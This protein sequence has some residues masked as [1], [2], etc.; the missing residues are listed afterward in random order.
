MTK[1]RNS[2]SPLEESSRYVLLDEAA[3]NRLIDAKLTAAQYRTVL[4][5]SLVDPFGNRFV[6]TSGQMA[7]QRLGISK[8]TYYDALSVLEREQL[9]EFEDVS[10]RVRNRAGSKSPEKYSDKKIVR[11]IGTQSEI[12]GSSPENQTPVREIGT[13][14]E[15]S[16][17]ESLKAFDIKISKTPQ[18]HSLDFNQD[19]N[20]L[21]KRENQILNF[22][23]EPNYRDW[24][25]AK[26]SRLPDPPTLR[27]L[28]LEKQSVN[29]ANLREYEAWQS[30]QQQIDP[31]PPPLPSEAPE[32][33]DE[34]IEAKLARYQKLWSITPMRKGIQNAIATHPEWKID[35]GSDGP[36]WKPAPPE[37]NSEPVPEL[38][39]SAVLHRL[40]N[41]IATQTPI[42]PQLQV[43]AD[44]CHI[45][46]LQLQA[47]WDLAA[48]PPGAAADDMRQAG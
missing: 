19:Q 10:L 46:I 26:A 37:Q 36:R 22:E 23:I 48:G 43:D 16:E 25:L 31:L 12:S 34:S 39:P 24:L 40:K 8:S 3:V 9:F 13:Q 2:S 21:K 15:I 11:E 35:I 41:A 17:N 30:V 7:R 33:E 27:E 45:D 29:P 6:D 18:Y 4:Y 38:E 44:R 47:E 1:I 14:S 28:W 32:S 5:F 42:T 20:S